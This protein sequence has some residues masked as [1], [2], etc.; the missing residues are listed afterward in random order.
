MGEFDWMPLERLQSLIGGLRECDES[1]GEF[2]HRFSAPPAAEK[3]FWSRLSVECGLSRADESDEDEDELANDVH[4]EFNADGFSYITN[5]VGVGDLG[6]AESRL[7][8]NMR[9]IKGVCYIASHEM[10]PLWREDGIKYHTLKIS[11]AC[12][13]HLTLSS[14]IGPAVAF[15]RA[16]QPALICSSCPKLRGCLSAA[17]LHLE[18]P[19]AMSVSACVEKLEACGVL[20]EPFS[21]MERE[22][23]DTVQAATDAK[24][25]LGTRHAPARDAR[26]ESVTV[27]L[28]QPYTRHA[29]CRAAVGTRRTHLSMWRQAPDRDGVEGAASSAEE[30]GTR[31]GAPG[32][33]HERGDRVR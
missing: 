15:L 1:C 9:G 20:T 11:P 30:G 28:I 22:A 29:A 31:A 14:Q 7:M 23:L 4:N 6:V 19:E 27:I 17:F 3:A 8:L 2:G 24:N 26:P 13:P 32:A 10:E 18:E 16:H 5:N 12:E 25:S 21:P 33:T